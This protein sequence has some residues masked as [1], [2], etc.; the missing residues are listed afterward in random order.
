MRQEARERTG[1]FL[2][3]RPENAGDAENFSGVE[4]EADIPVGIAA[5]K[6]IELEHDVVA[7]RPLQGFA[8]IFRLEPPSD[9]Q[10][11]E[12]LDIGFRRLPFGDDPPVLHDVDPIGKLEHFAQRCETKMNEARAFSA[13]T[14][15]NRI[16]ISGRSSTD[17]GSSSRMTR[18]PDAC[19][20][21]VSAFASSTI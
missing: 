4:L 10:T 12:R 3:A 6:A 15:A 17:V 9:H 2:A 21:R 8:I 20:S 14:R 13:R 18:R 19:S 16:S 7:K 5:T 1:Q 11:V